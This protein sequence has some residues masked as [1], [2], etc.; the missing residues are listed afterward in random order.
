MRRSQ[1]LLSANS[2]SPELLTA[3]AYLERING[4]NDKARKVYKVGL[5]SLAQGN[6]AGVVR[7]LWGAVELEWL[8]FQNDAALELILRGADQSGERTSVN[9]LRAKRRLEEICQ[10]KSTSEWKLRLNWIKLRILLELLTG[11]LEATIATVKRFQANEERDELERESLTVASLLMIYHHTVTLHN[12]ASPALLRKLVYEGLEVYPSNSVILGLF[13][14]CEKGEGVWGRVRAL[15]GEKAEGM[16][17]GKSVARRLIEVW[18]ANWE[19]G[20]WLGEVERVRAG[21]EAA[22]ACDRFKSY[23]FLLKQTAMLINVCSTKGSAII[24]KTF[25]KFE[26]AAGNL[27]RAKSVLFRALGQCPLVKG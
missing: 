20:R 2:S 19:E 11:T 27:K 24:W 25:V 10:Q 15:M 18:I 12:H 21:L 9:I 13:L 26:I 14:E 22:V 17:Q 7:L 23:L 6:E 4:K 3:H 1:N 8:L 5:D 16:L